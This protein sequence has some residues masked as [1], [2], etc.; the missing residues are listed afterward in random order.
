MERVGISWG[1]VRDSPQKR[2]MEFKTIKEIIDEALDC[3]T[4]KRTC[5]KRAIELTKE[6]VLGLIDEQFD[7]SKFKVYC[8]FGHWLKDDIEELKARI[9]GTSE[10]EQNGK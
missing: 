4:N 3:S 6:D 2:K 10:K 7:K 8:H 9:T 1:L 5:I